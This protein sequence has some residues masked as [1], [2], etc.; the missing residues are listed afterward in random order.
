M[1]MLHW[2]LGHATE[3]TIRKLVKRKLLR[4]LDVSL[5]DLGHLREPCTACL[6]GRAKRAP[7]DGTIRRSTEVGHTFSVDERGPFRQLDASGHT[8]GYFT[9]CGNLPVFL[10]PMRGSALQMDPSGFDRRSA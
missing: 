1:L 6:C 5:Q 8:Q 9:G 10:E 4:G 3:K 2:K 7:S